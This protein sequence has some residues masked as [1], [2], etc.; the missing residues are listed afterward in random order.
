MSNDTDEHSASTDGDTDAPWRPAPACQAGV[1]PPSNMA[2][3]SATQC[4][5][6]L[7][8]FLLGSAMAALT[9]QARG[10]R[11]AALLLPL[12]W[13]A[14]RAHAAPTPRQGSTDGNPARCWEA[15]LQEVHQGADALPWRRPLSQPDEDTPS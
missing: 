3:G 14:G 4:R 8:L 13:M 12:L 5:A 7:P 6:P 9:P 11:A 2:A 10:H 1:L 15:R